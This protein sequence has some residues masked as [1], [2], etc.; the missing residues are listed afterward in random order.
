MRGNII[1]NHF[2]DFRWP[3]FLYTHLDC[4]L[5]AYTH[6]KQASKLLAKIM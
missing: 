6:P 5:L 4:I 3:N 2:G 1:N